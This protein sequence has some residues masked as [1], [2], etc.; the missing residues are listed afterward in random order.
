MSFGRSLDTKEP[1]NV[2]VKSSAPTF[3]R[4]FVPQLLGPSRTA[5]LPPSSETLD[6]LL[7]LNAVVRESLRLCNTAPT[8]NPRLTL[9]NETTKIGT[10]DEIPGDV[11]ISGFA[12]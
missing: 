2:S 6:Q 10:Y 3:P 8:S 5:F 11:R 1:N 12:W 7:Y 4:R 9:E